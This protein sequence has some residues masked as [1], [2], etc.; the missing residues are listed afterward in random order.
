MR[1]IE[2]ERENDASVGDKRS[3]C[4]VSPN[5]THKMH[6]SCTLSIPLY[7][8]AL[9]D[10]KVRSR[11]NTYITYYLH[12][13]VGSIIVSKSNYNIIGTPCNQFHDE[14]V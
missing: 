12:T 11:H 13:W 3:E 4:R 6:S 7:G 9:I 14:K 1:K 5:T 2:S 10:K 8:R